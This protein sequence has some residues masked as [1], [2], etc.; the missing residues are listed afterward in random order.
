MK[1]TIVSMFVFMMLGVSAQVGAVENDAIVV[2]KPSAVSDQDSVFSCIGLDGEQQ[3]HLLVENK[4]KVT[5]IPTLAKIS[6]KED[7]F[8]QP[9]EVM[10]ATVTF[11]ESDFYAKYSY[12]IFDGKTDVPVGTLKL[13]HNYLKAAPDMVKKPFKICGRGSCLPKAD[14]TIKYQAILKI[15]EKEISFTCK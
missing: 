11:E 4:T 13:V 3:I 1:K 2:E 7:M 12:N 5:A 8:A 14:S 10:N 6:F 15:Y 9:Y